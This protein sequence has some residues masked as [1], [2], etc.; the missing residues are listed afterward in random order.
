MKLLG[1]IVLALLAFLALT[2]DADGQ[3]KQSVSSSRFL[4]R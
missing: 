4:G 1:S 3:R 2:G